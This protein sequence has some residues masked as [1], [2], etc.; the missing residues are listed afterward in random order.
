MAAD[1]AVA[2]PIRESI[3]VDARR[4]SSRK[5]GAASCGL[6]PLLPVAW[7]RA[8]IRSASARPWRSSAPDPLSPP[9]AAD[10]PAIMK[11]MVKIARS[12]STTSC[13]F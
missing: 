13:L 4:L 7:H 9:K 5:V 12:R 11:P 6:D 3:E 8:H 2:Q 1:Q 10:K